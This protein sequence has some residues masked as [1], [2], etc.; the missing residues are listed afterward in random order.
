MQPLAPV[1]DALLQA[2]KTGVKEKR[3]TLQSLWPEIVGAS[4]A[5]HT[6][7]SL[8][9]SGTLYVWVDDSTLASELNQRY[10]GTILK[11]SQAALGEETVRKVVFG[12][13]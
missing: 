10:L 11:R 12:V 6:R 3:S 5:P 13:G 4:L 1:L 7:P 2:L 8:R 9:P